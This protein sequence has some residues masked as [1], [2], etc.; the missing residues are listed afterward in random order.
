M[1]DFYVKE[2][3]MQNTIRSVTIILKKHEEK[4]NI[5]IIHIFNNKIFLVLF[6]H[7]IIN[8]FKT[9]QEFLYLLQLCKKISKSVK[10]YI[11]YWN[12]FKIVVHI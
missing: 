2:L 11:V 9:K 10:T 12:F 8:I 7:L 4:N 6:I 3:T 5:L 1:K